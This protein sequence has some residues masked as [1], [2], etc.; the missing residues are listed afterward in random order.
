METTK[1]RD[2]P[3]LAIFAFL[4]LAYVGTHLPLAL[5][6]SESEN[7]IHELREIDS[8]LERLKTFA[9]PN[10]AL[11]IT[12][13]QTAT[14]QA[15]GLISTT[16]EVGNLKVTRQFVRL[17][18]KFSLADGI[19]ANAVTKHTEPLVGDLNAKFRE[20]TSRR[21]LSDDFSLLLTRSFFQEI[22]NNLIALA[23]MNSISEMPAASGGTIRDQLILLSAKAKAVKLEASDSDDIVVMTKGSALAAEII[24][25]PWVP[26]VAQSNAAYRVLNDILSGCRRFIERTHYVADRPLPGTQDGTGGR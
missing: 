7:T 5:A 18:I 26:Q 6:E 4:G 1:R 16:H 22:E 19:Y 24:Q 13:L 14:Q 2:Q 10:T 21:L 20:F 15:I 25:A 12:D 11:R 9:K 17:Y 3:L 8:R 23:K